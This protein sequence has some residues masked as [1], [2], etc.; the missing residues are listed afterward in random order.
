ML[1]NCR[2]P[3]LRQKQSFRASAICASVANHPGARSRKA[4]GAA[5]RF[6]YQ[7]RRL[8]RT[9]ATAGPV[10]GLVL[11]QRFR[12]MRAALVGCNG[13][14]PFRRHAEEIRRSQDHAWRRD[15]TSRTILRIVALGHRPHIREG[16]TLAAEIFVDRHF[17]PHGFPFRN[18]RGC[19]CGAAASPPS[20]HPSRRDYLSG[21][22]DTS[23]PPLMCLIGPADDGM[24]S[25]SK[26]SVGRYSVAQ[27][28]GMSTTPLI[29]PCTGAT[30]RIV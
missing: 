2:C 14:S 7:A 11:S 29:W 16:T 9:A 28:L 18:N 8:G 24:I 10:G 19:E 25:K 6:F 20:P 4:L 26:I 27:A 17:S 3:L 5:F 1:S 15:F 30:P 12:R 23:T 13:L 22:S 21:D